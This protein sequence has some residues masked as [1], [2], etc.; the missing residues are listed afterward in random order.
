ML[1]MTYVGRQGRRLLGQADANQLIDF[2]DSIGNSGQMMGSMHFARNGDGSC[3]G[4]NG[5]RPAAVV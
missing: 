5:H 3:Q 4:R 1:K 2:P